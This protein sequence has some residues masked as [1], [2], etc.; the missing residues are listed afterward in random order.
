MEEQYK[1]LFTS[2]QSTI[3]AAAGVAS[4]DISFHRRLDKTLDRST[5]KN[6]DKLLSLASRIMQHVAKGEVEELVTEEPEDDLTD[7]WHDVNTALDTLTFKID[8]CL[9]QHRLQFKSSES[10]DKSESS[11][12]NSNTTKLS[13]KRTRMEATQLININLIYPSLK[14]SFKHLSTTA[15]TN[16]SDLEL[17]QN[18]MLLYRLMILFD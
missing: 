17:H 2:L 7:S 3:R 14:K 10:K 13:D 9:Q 4:Q 1:S 8:E 16:L 11:K 5:S 15:K 18:Q 12:P 6:S